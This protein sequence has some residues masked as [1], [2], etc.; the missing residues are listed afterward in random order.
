MSIDNLSQTVV[1]Y[2]HVWAILW[3]VHKGFVGDEVGIWL[4]L[5]RCERTTYLLLLSNMCKEFVA[6]LVFTCILLFVYAWQH[7]H[8]NTVNLALY[9]Y[10][11]QFIHIHAS[12][13]NSH[14]PYVEQNSAS[15]H[16][17]HNSP[18]NQPFCPREQ[19]MIQEHPVH[20]DEDTKRTQYYTTM[21]TA[22]F[23]TWSNRGKKLRYHT[24]RHKKLHS[25]LLLQWNKP[26][27]TK[28]TNILTQY[29]LLHTTNF[30]LFICTIIVPTIVK[31]SCIPCANN[32]HQ[33]TSP[34]M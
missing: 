6:A 30:P 14:D 2:Y 7:V 13:Y 34:Y 1:A 23:T 18:S 12:G 9:T 5:T 8:H 28:T 27:K 33:P 11:I 15:Q 32:P 17:R 10:N 22:Y 21:R 25:G 19:D 26:G 4:E 24:H 3:A 31:A 20:I 29:F 16:Q